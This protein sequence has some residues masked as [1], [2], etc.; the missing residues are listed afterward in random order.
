M[1]NIL[2]LSH[3]VDNV[4]TTSEAEN[5]I[6][7]SAFPEKKIGSVLSLID[8]GRVGDASALTTQ[9]QTTDPFDPARA[10]GG[11]PL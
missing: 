4:V 6:V 5:A 9:K 10:G 1:L 3:I 8:D 7:F 11:S 2:C